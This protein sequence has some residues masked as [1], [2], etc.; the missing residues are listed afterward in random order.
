MKGGEK[1]LEVRGEEKKKAKPEVEVESD[2]DEDEDDDDEGAPKSEG[3]PRVPDLLCGMSSA[4]PLQPPYYIN[5]IY[6]VYQEEFI[7][8]FLKASILYLHKI[9][10]WKT[11]NFFET[12]FQIWQQQK[13]VSSL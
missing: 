7:L 5:P 9:V 2:D 6:Q 1:S 11:E 10:L 3:Q 12:C 13:F 4:A 8:T